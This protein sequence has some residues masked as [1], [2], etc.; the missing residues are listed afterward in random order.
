M[1]PRL[2]SLHPTTDINT[3]LEPAT[4]RYVKW[5]THLNQQEKRASLYP[6]VINIYEFLLSYLEK[7][8]TFITFR[9]LQIGFS[10]NYSK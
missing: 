6:S 5:L 4:K 9:I 7:I 1:I 8:S 10:R 3:D 2:S